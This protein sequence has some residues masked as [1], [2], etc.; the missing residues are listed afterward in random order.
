VKSNRSKFLTATLPFCY[1]EYVVFKGKNLFTINECAILDSFQVLIEDLESLTYA[2]YF[3]ELIDICINEMESSHDLFRLFVSALYLMKSKAVDLD[4]LARSF[5]VKL[6]EATGYRLYLDNCCICKKKIKTSNYISFQYSGGICSDCAKTN[7]IK[8]SNATYN[9]LNYLISL[10]LEKV[11]RVSAGKDI[12][13]ELYKIL[14]TFISTNYMKKPKSL[15][16]LKYLEE[17]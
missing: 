14:S 3:C 13:D 10:P 7:G 1:G 2:S 17:E 4:M 9:L 15:N 8:I 12:R 11:Y 16:A 5:E 6:L